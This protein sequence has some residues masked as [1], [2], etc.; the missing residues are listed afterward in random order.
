MS[1]VGDGAFVWVCLGE[2]ACVRATASVWGLQRGRFP[3]DSFSKKTS[4]RAGQRRV[5]GKAFVSRDYLSKGRC[6][7]APS[8]LP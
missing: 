6:P 1:E 2:R 8:Y 7:G 5:G 3:E 4:V